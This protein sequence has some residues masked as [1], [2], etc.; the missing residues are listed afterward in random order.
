MRTI[1]VTYDHALFH[2]YKSPIRHQAM[3]KRGNQLGDCIWP[4]NLPHGFFQVCITYP[5]LSPPK[6]LDQRELYFDS[7]CRYTANKIVK[8]VATR[9][10]GQI[11][12]SIDVFLSIAG[13]LTPLED[14]TSDECENVLRKRLYMPS[15]KIHSPTNTL[16]PKMQT[17]ILANQGIASTLLKVHSAFGSGFFQWVNGPLTFCSSELQR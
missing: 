10:I 17:M 11:S 13:A 1:S 15:K 12:R 8:D 3:N 4:L 6:G 2:T 16:T 9:W 7:L 5:F 14:K